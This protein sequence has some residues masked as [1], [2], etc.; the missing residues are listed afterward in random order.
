MTTTFFVVVV[1]AAIT[2]VVLLPDTNSNDCCFCRLSPRLN[3][4]FSQSRI[5][6]WL[7][8]TTS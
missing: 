6:P 2:T 7:T 1:A 5:I 8:T 4:V 3:F